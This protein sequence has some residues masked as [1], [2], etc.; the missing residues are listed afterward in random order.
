MVRYE[1]GIVVLWPLFTIFSLGFT[2]GRN[3]EEKTGS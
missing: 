3:T 2:R 1:G